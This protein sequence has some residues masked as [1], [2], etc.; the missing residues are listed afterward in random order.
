MINE[1]QTYTLTDINQLVLSAEKAEQQE[2]DGTGKGRTATALASL[3][4]AATETLGIL[5]RD[6]ISEDTP[7]KEF[8]KN[9]QNTIVF[10]QALSQ[11]GLDDIPESDTEI[12]YPTIRNGITHSLF[13]KLGMGIGYNSAWKAQKK[14]LIIMDNTLHLNVAY[15]ADYVKLAIETIIARYYSN[16][17][18]K[19]QLDRNFHNYTT[20]QTNHLKQNVELLKLIQEHYPAIYGY[21]R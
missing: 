7:H 5:L 21:Y 3:L 11:L 17:S 10:F 4:F 16:S 15:L 18:F 20:I 1:L 6:D 2:N 13:P 9:E 14:L 12:V 19:E 8:T